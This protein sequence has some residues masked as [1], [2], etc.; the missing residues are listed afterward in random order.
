MLNW[1]TAQK[2]KTEETPA[3]PVA[4]TMNIGATDQAISVNVEAWK[5]SSA[6]L[7]WCQCDARMAVKTTANITTDAPS[8]HSRAAKVNCNSVIAFS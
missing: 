4:N 1:P 5:C 7:W 3:S 8:S 6:C 2:L